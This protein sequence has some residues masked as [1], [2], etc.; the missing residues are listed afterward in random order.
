MDG[1]GKAEDRIGTLVLVHS[2]LVGPGTWRALAPRL[3][4]HGYEVLVPDLRGAL[5]AEPPLYFRIG[6]LIAETIDASRGEIAL[7]VHSGAGA[8]VPMLARGNKRVRRAIFV[9]ALLP[10][11][12]KRWFDTAPPDLVTHLRSQAKAGN[13][14]RWH[15]WWPRGAIEA[16]VPDETTRAAFIAELHEVPLAYLEEAAPLGDVPRGVT[17]AYLQLSTAC[18]PQAGEAERRGWPVRRL[19]LN[20]LALLTH[21]A[22]VEAEV[23]ELLAPEKR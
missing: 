1:T 18:M 17:C 15:R 12:G 16:I 14:P 2:P 22:A 3:E 23:M 20:H 9:D 11:P 10:H 6:R 5:R 21:P 4:A 13:L 19:D 8:L 7:I